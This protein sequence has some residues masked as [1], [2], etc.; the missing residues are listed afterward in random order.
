MPKNPP[1]G[2]PRLTPYLYYRDVPAALE[3]L[4]KAFGF[5]KLMAHDGPDGS[6]MH[7]EMKLADAVIMMGPASDEYG[8]KSPNDLPGVHQSLYVYVDNVDA[9]FE[10]ARSSGARIVRGPA[11]QFYGDRNYTAQDCEGHHWHFAKHTKDIPPEEL[12]PPEA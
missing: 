4:A 1:E 10:R 11:D 2:M 3:W 6:I 7:A 12:K 5:K 8:T 9:H